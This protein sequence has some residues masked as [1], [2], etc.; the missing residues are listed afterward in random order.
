MSSKAQSSGRDRQCEYKI[1][2]R[3]LSRAAA[4]WINGNSE[5][6]GVREHPWKY[7][8]TSLNILVTF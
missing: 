5:I 7:H 3:Q 2:V 1:L 8:L 6:L 4:E